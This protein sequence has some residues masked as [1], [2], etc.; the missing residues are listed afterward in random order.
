MII[1]YIRSSSYTCHELCPMKWFIEYN[2]GWRGPS[3]IK[4]EK[5][6][7][8]HKVLEILA[9]IKLKQQQG[10]TYFTD[11]IVGRIYVNKY[12]LDKIID[13]CTD[14]YEKHSVHKWKPIDRKHCH[15]WVYKAIE[16]DNG[17]YDPR[18]NIIVQPEQSF[19]IV[20]D[21]PWSKYEY[22][23]PDGKVIS[24]NLSI[25]GTID[26]ISQIDDDTYQ[27]LDWKGLPGS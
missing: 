2:L 19:D 26:Q 16:Y 8:V 24:G 18:N 5:G 14:F 21:K 23:L 10:K 22:T 7:V 1:T 15:K 17:L 4:A 13:K 6:T 12:D 25:K 9:I 11:D 27:I 3:G 20:I